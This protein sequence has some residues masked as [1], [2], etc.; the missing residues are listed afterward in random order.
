M[1]YV[2]RPRAAFYELFAFGSVIFPGA[3]AGRGREVEGGI[4]RA[5]EPLMEMITDQEM[6]APEMTSD[7]RPPSTGER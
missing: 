3:P 7:D 5:S 1:D 2:R 6:D 4:R